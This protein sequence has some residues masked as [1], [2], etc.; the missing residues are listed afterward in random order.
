MGLK[1]AAQ[2]ATPDQV[3]RWVEKQFEKKASRREVDVINERLDAMDAQVQAT[4]DRIYRY[5]D[6]ARLVRSICNQAQATEKTGL[7]KQILDITSGMEATADQADIAEAP[8]TVQV[9]AMRVRNM[10]DKDNALELSRDALAGI[11][12]AGSRQDYELARLR[13]ATR[14]IGVLCPPANDDAGSFPA[15]VRREIQ[16]LAPS[17]PTTLP[18]Q[19]AA[20][21]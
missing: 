19:P 11:R 18:S 12:S 10:A 20:V 14:R 8:R 2:A 3:T 13:M 6:F 17:K 9:Q 1:G 15:D 16:Q 4:R 5:R 21:K 7:A